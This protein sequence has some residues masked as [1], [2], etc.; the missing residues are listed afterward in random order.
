MVVLFLVMSTKGCIAIGTPRKW[1]G[2]WARHFPLKEV[3]DEIHKIGISKFSKELLEYETWDDYLS[4][5][6]DKWSKNNQITQESVKHFPMLIEWVCIID[7]KKKLFHVLVFNRKAIYKKIKEK[8]DSGMDPIE[9]DL[10]QLRKEEHLDRVTCICEQRHEL[11][12][13]FDLDG[14]EPDWVEVWKKEEEM[15]YRF[16]E[17]TF[18]DKKIL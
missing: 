3:W 4:K 5:E 8:A 14:K 16:C 13:T 12:A 10:K 15:F 2:G 17:C 9:K 7:P 6:K 18:H 1:R 11:V